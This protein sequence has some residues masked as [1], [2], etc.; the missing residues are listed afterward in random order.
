[1]PQLIFPLVQLMRSMMWSEI[2]ISLSLIA[3]F[4][5]MASPCKSLN[6]QLVML[7]PIIWL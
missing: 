2:K 3:T 7:A 4:H 6:L 1:M 5:S